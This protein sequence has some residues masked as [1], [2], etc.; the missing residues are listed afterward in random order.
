MKTKI[1]ITLNS[2]I[3]K[4]VDS[5]IDNLIIRN[6]SQSVE[7][8]IKRSLS[9]NKT[10][11]ILAGGD[12]N[13]LKI[14]KDIYRPI[15][16]LINIT[17]I[18]LSIKKLRRNNF[19]TIFIVGRKPILTEIFKIVGNGSEYGVKIEFIEEK[20]SSGTADSLRLLRGHI[21]TVF[22]VVWCDIIF[23]NINIKE[24]WSEHI[25]R[26]ATATLLIV[27][28]PKADKTNGTIIMEGNEVKKFIEKPSKL[29]SFIFFSG[30]FIAE[31][32]IFEY[33][34]HSLELDVFPKLAERSLLYGY[35]SGEEYLHFHSKK[36]IQKIIKKLKYLKIS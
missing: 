17:A 8:L 19:K 33:V 7:Y 23:N 22:L 14:E 20:S 35:L 34:G 29:E 11:V 25:K 4:E 18:E 31:P 5:I 13:K 28:S 12:V 2:N 27:S 10:A 30:M 32:E 1:S 36:D 16:K 9:E 26:K 3:L 6:R 21:K 24:F 15:A